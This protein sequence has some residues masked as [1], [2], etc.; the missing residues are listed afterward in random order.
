MCTLEKRGNLFILT[1][2]GDEEHCL[3]PTLIATILS[4]LSQVKAQVTRGSVLIT[5]SHKKFFSNGFD[6]PWAQVVGSKEGA[7]KRLHYMVESLKLMVGAFL[8]L[9]MPTISAVTGHAAAA[10]LMIAL[11]HDYVFIRRDKGV[12]YMSEIDIGLTLPDY[13][14]ALVTTRISSA[15]ARRE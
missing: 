1:L 8:S 15:S 10:G 12:L 13:F 3:D 2:I 14:T 4:T 5:I 7:A 11:S 6:L 9:P